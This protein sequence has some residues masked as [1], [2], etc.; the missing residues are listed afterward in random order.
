MIILDSS[1]W[2]GYFRKSDTV[3]RELL[4][5][6]QILLHPFVFG[7]LLLGGLPTK[8]DIS[9]QLLSLMQCPVASPSESV[10]FIEWAKLAGT[11]IGYVDTHLLISAKLL[12]GGKIL[13]QDKSLHAQAEKLGL[14][15]I[16]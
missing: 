4:A 1:V 13:T 7:E 2:I 12:D 16:P 15:Y 8:C 9:E 5:E 3:V 11:G 10:A 6:G 14:A